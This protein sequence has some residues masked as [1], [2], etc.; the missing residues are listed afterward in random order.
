MWERV[1]QTSVAIAKQVA[2]QGPVYTAF[3]PKLVDNIQRL[4]RSAR[5]TNG[6]PIG[7]KPDKAELPRPCWMRSLSAKSSAI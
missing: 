2:R 1:P 6:I 4:A 3:D 7:G 5:A